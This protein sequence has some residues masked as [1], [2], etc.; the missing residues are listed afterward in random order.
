MLIRCD[1]AAAVEVCRGSSSSDLANVLVSDTG[2]APERYTVFKDLPK[3]DDGSAHKQRQPPALTPRQ[4]L[5]REKLEVP[6]LY[7]CSFFDLK[8]DDESEADIHVRFAEMYKELATTLYTGIFITQLMP[9]GHY[10]DI[11]FQLVEDLTALKLDQR[12]GSI[13]EFPL[14]RVTKLQRAIRCGGKIFRSGPKVP[15]RLP[16]DA[17]HIVIMFFSRHQLVFVFKALD[18]AVSFMSCLELLVR[19]AKHYDKDLMRIPRPKVQC[20]LCGSACV[21][22]QSQSKGLISLCSPSEEYTGERKS[23]SPHRIEKL[24]IRDV[25]RHEDESYGG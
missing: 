7:T 13:I 19:K 15:D 3:L 22:Q 10:K 12:N 5:V 11:H 25:A 20:S 17:R 23:A 1:C 6:P 14:V 16:N 4:R 21:D 9:D 8:S 24:V 2:S 18:E